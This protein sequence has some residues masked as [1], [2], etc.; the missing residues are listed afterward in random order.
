MTDID[1]AKITGRYCFRGRVFDSNEKT[2]QML[3][4]ALATNG[5]NER[6][7]KVPDSTPL[8]KLDKYGDV[9]E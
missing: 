5:S 1:N 4:L 8:T 7:T 6:Y 2:I 3:N 9:I